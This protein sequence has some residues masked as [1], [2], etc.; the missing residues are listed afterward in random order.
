MELNM[1]LIMINIVISL[2][3][4]YCLYGDNDDNDLKVLRWMR[5]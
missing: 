2:S 4:V 3:I 1:S 5:K